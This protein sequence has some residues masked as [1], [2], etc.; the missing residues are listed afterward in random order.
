MGI[1]T[2]TSTS[3]TALVTGASS[4]IG[5]AIAVE[6]AAQGW[7]LAL[8]AR[9]V[10][11]LAETAAK[12]RAQGAAEVYAGVLDVTDDASIERFFEESESAL[13]TADVVVNNAGASRFHWIEETDP[14]WLRSEIE[15]NLIGPMLVTHRAL[16]SL[17]AAGADGDVVIVSS[18]A[19]RLPRPGQLAYGASKAGL[20]NYADALSMSLEGTGVRVIKLRLGPTF[21]EFGQSLDLTPEGTRSRTAYW[22]QFGLRD[23][24][25][26][27]RSNLGLL[28]PDDVAREVVHA[29]TQPRHVLL[30]TIELQP[31][32]PRK[33]DGDST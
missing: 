20:E 15:T 13:G 27:T 6:M 30:D 17:L 4:G 10:D 18:D 21:S 5:A 9:R 8:G 28:M 11:R 31:S 12:A 26:M 23:A 25:M 19:A 3:R 33:T 16:A 24:R 22:A 2:M 29:V 1:Q 32:V 7:K 14:R